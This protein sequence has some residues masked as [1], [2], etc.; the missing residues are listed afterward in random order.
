[1][2]AEHLPGS[3]GECSKCG[4]K[5]QVQTNG[6]WKHVESGTQ[7]HPIRSV[8]IG[9]EGS[10]TK[11][12]S[13]DFISRME[14]AKA[15]RTA[16]IVPVDV[17]DLK[18]RGR[19]QARKGTKTP[20]PARKKEKEIKKKSI[21]QRNRRDRYKKM[22]AGQRLKEVEARQQKAAAAKAQ[23]EAEPELLPDL[24]YS[25]NP[26]IGLH[27]PKKDSPDAVVNV[28]T[29]DIVVPKTGQV[30]GKFTQPIPGIDVDSKAVAAGKAHLET[31]PEH[32]WE[33]ATDSSNLESTGRPVPLIGPGP[34]EDAKRPSRIDDHYSGMLEWAHD[35]KALFDKSDRY[36][37]TL[38]RPKPGVFQ[39]IKNAL[40][41][42]HDATYNTNRWIVKRRLKYCTDCAPTTYN[43]TTQKETKNKA[44]TV[45]RP[46]PEELPKL[47]TTTGADTGNE[48]TVKNQNVK[49][50]RQE[51]GL[52]GPQLK[53]GPRENVTTWSDTRTTGFVKGS[54]EGK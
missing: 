1:M 45:T 35:H 50:I 30:L 4:T 44:Q 21:T 22:T 11:D 9:L 3:F 37:Y 31:H 53:R 29:R 36:E 40:V 27:Y 48:G 23:R 38:V 54:G 32:A 17:E 41:N 10:L 16:P 24:H 51:M 47:N 7:T 6:A 28:K 25:K 19:S 49:A 14:I 52:V 34:D 8:K 33:V 42:E 2:A 43:L 20:G 26:K 39:R 13:D 5:V 46:E 15:I 18:K 12:E